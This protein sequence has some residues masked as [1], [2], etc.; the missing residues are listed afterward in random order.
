MSTTLASGAGPHSINEQGID[1]SEK[2]QRIAR[3]R[4]AAVTPL[5]CKEDPC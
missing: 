3:K 5:F 2:Y 1:I 4:L